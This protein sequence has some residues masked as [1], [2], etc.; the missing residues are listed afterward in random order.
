M[1]RSS[2]EKFGVWFVAFLPFTGTVLAI[3]FAFQLGYVAAR[4]LWLMLG[5]Y[6][7][8]AL[9]ITVGYHR[10]LTHNSF[11]P[12]PPIKFL[13]LMLGSMAMQGPALYWATVHWKHHVHSDK[14]EDPHSPWW[15][16]GI[17]L[18]G[19]KG[20]SWRNFKLRAAA[21]WHS[22]MGWLFS[23]DISWD[24]TDSV[25]QKFL[26]DKMVVFFSK[27]FVLWVALRFYIC[28]LIGG[29]TGMLWGGCVCLLLTQQVTYLVN[30]AT[31]IVGFRDFETT[32]ESRNNWLVAVFAMGEGWHNN[33]HKFMWSARHGMKWWQFDM[34]YIVIKTLE[35]LRLVSNVRV[36]KQSQLEA[37]REAVESTGAESVVY[38]RDEKESAKRERV[39]S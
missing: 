2:I 39:A 6:I 23:S 38:Q 19:L 9:G 30:S 12:T 31:H 5:W 32:D 20:F 8:T 16:D 33:H 35:A 13:F 4:D 15:W 3:A 14:E 29:W 34:S 36:P 22:H 17:H 1:N 21:A 10:M 7:V 26:S 24:P 25:Q 37:A 28:Y 27:T 11:K 18:K